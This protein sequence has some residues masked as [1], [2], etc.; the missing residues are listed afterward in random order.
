MASELYVR[1]KELC[2][3]KGVRGATMSREIGLSPNLM[4][5]LKS[6]RKK[7]LSAKSAEKIARYFG[8]SVAYLLGEEEPPVPSLV[9]GDPELTDY[10][11]QL[12]E[13]S[14]M[15][16]LFHVTKN[17]TREQI[18]AIVKM[19]ESLQGKVDS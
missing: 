7:G 9:N 2:E 18:E 5:E 19:V 6:G 1:I 14:E 16:M 4:T 10:L 15:R 3:K 17:A 8:V 12:S 11:Q 13:R